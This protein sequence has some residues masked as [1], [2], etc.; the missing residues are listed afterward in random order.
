MGEDLAFTKIAELAREANED[1]WEA[2]VDKYTNESLSEDNA[3]S[4]ANRKLKDAD[5]DQFMS[6]YSSLVQNLLQ[7]QNGKLHVKVMN[8]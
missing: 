6:R 1:K 7:L 2:K 5:M 8:L 4:K 3:R